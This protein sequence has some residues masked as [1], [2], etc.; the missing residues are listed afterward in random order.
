MSALPPLR[1]T[2]AQ[3][4]SVRARM[5]DA[6]FRPVPL[7]NW[8][9][10]EVPEASRGKR[11]MGK[12]WQLMARLDPP[13]AVAAVPHFRALNT[14][15]LCDGLRVIDID[16][17]N[18]E[19]AGRI[20][21]QAFAILGEA[22]VRS[23]NNAGRCA[24]FYR[25]TA[26]EP[27]RR[28]VVG[29]EGKLEVLGHGQQVHVHGPHPSGA[30]L[31]WH[32]GMP[33]DFAR[34][35]LIAVSEEQ[36]TA[37]LDFAGPLLGMSA[38][39]KP[40]S[41]E[42]DGTPPPHPG[43]AYGPSADPQDVAAAL[44]VIPNSGPPDWEAWNRVGMA[45]WSA[46]AGAETGYVAWFAWSA[47]HPAHDGAACAERWRAYATSPPSSIGAG[48]LFHLARQ[49]RPGW[50]PPTW[51]TTTPQ[52]LS[53][54]L[55]ILQRSNRPAPDFPVLLLGSWWADWVTRAAEGANAP[56]DYVALPLL[57]GASALMGNAR[58]A[59]G[60]D[61]W[62]E[63]PALWGAA[64]GTPSSG[65]SPGAAPVLGA[66]L[67]QVERD[68]A[69]GFEAKLKTWMEAKQVCDAINA[70]WEK[71]VARAVKG[72]QAIPAK[73]LE[74]TIGDQ[75]IRPRVKIM[76]ATV[77]AVG[78]I[79]AALPKGVMLVR[80]ELA[81]W[82]LNLA[83]YSGGTDRPFWLEA[84]VGGAYRVDRRSRPEPL[85]IP[86]LA[87]PVF[88]TIQPDRLAEV[89]GKDD[90]GLAA[91]FLWTWP[92]SR[93]FRRPAFAADHDGAVQALGRL[94]A[95]M[96]ATDDGGEFVPSFVRLDENGAKRLEAFGRAMQEREPGSHGLLRSALG[97][98][99]GQALRLALVLTFLRWC[100]EGGPEPS[101][102]SCEA[103][104]AAAALLEDY[105]LPMAERVL[106]DASIP[107][108]ERDARTLA[109]HIVETHAAHVNVSVLRDKARL[110]GLRETE[111]VKAA[112]QF[113]AEAGW[114]LPPVTNVTGGRPRGDWTV[115]P[116]LWAA[117]QREAV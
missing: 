76:D 108:A 105:F 77:E 112:C 95:L 5:W 98:A 23:R 33:G 41:D 54:E 86:R 100:V 106:A 38:D 3:A 50:Q 97:K 56:P 57:I 49:A 35:D 15:M 28:A 81:G 17:D 65:K 42:P 63:P 6:G 117:L 69:A 104:E 62:R 99:R 103:L 61:G 27:G 48:T 114:L 2:V 73:P 59:L 66:V 46:T 79:V 85:F 24:L 110:P 115:N 29:T 14:G 45:T 9:E 82:L 53:L 75:P 60:W 84:Y 78:A 68:M 93:P 52:N 30:W 34:D 20:R 90:D 13:H 21:A 71:D 91:R 113:L 109:L 47:Q 16:V 64:V 74:A 11:P 102:I 37:L 111:T 116:V 36:V 94:A 88:G 25:A 92:E 43:S 67:T 51:Q 107:Q 70:Q 10:P 89:L 101:Q 22:P 83:R 40:A 31:A 12:D 19:L 4:Q 80:D 26:G 58:W 8:D 96:M 39:D 72:G 18:P 32:P 87:I 44:A 7:Y 1:P 55:G